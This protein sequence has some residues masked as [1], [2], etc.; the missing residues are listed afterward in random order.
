MIPLAEKQTKEKSIPQNNQLPPGLS[1][2]TE[3]A[4]VVNDSMPTQFHFGSCL[5]NRSEKIVHE[6]EYTNGNLL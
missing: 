2:Y 1:T 4:S 3:T 5:E 6:K